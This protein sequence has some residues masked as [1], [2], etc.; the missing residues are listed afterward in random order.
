MSANP[1][2]LGRLLRLIWPARFARLG[3]LAL[4]VRVVRLAFL[5]MR[6]ASLPCMIRRLMVAALALD[7][8]PAGYCHAL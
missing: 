4:L 2:N 6:C 3:G 8:H 1:R 5:L 7:P